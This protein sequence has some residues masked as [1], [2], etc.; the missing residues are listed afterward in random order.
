MKRAACGLLLFLLGWLT[1]IP[2]LLLRRKR[3]IAWFMH[4][5]NKYWSATKTW[6]M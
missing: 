4:E 6:K 5:F 2:A 1:V 3:Y